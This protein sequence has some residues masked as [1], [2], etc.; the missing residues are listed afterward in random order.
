MRIWAPLERSQ[1]VQPP[2]RFPAFY[3]NSTHVLLVKFPIFCNTS[4]TP[5]TPLKLRRLFLPFEFTLDS[6][7]VNSWTLNLE[8]ICSI[9]MSVD[10]QHVT[11]RYIRENRS[12]RN[13]RCEIYYIMLQILDTEY[14]VQT[15]GM[16]ECLCARVFVNICSKS[17]WQS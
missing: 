17:E 6:C 8:V 12:I 3:G 11:C 7:W 15:E 2:G 1:V 9:E 4:T 14:N 10:Y 5:C 16:I 13:Y